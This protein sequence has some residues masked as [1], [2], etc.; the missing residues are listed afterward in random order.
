MGDNFFKRRR[1]ELDMSQYDVARKVGITDKSVSA[2]E[3]GET[4]PRRSLWSKVAEAY[5]IS[6]ERLTREINKLTVTEA[7]AK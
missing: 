3:R 1:D 7:A 6:V 2:W 4:M 5:Q